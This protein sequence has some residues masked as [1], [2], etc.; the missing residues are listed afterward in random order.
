MAA[1]SGCH[2]SHKLIHVVEDKRG[3]DAQSLI[4]DAIKNR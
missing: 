2:S 1:Q 4:R 3:L